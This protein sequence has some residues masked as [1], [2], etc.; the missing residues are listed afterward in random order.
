MP[1]VLATWEAEIGMIVVRG[2]PRQINQETP[3]SK[4][5]E[6]NGLEVWLKL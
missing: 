1:V 5:T 3:I 6:Q 2:Q 4:I